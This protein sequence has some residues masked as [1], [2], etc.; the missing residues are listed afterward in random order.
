MRAN[1]LAAGIAVAALASLLAPVRAEFDGR[2]GD[3]DGT[4]G[5]APTS[6]CNRR[7]CWS[8]ADDCCA[9]YDEAYGCHDGLQPVKTTLGCSVFE[10]VRG[11]RVVEGLSRR[12]GS[13]GLYPRVVDL[14]SRQ[15]FAA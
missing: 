15:T 8:I 10:E 9:P 1:T 12:P 3:G 5:A 4:G 14:V 7:A 6:K 2:F 11:E 13:P